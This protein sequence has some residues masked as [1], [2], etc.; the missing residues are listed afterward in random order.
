MNT[1]ELIKKCDEIRNA[2]IEENFLRATET[3]IPLE[4]SGIHIVAKRKAAKL[5]QKSLAKLSGV[6]YGTLQRIERGDEN[7]SVGNLLK[8]LNCLGIKAGVK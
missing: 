7:V 6:S 2:L 1:E 3:Y 8:V 4:K 5:T